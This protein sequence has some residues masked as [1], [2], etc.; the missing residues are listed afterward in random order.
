MPL[1]VRLPRRVRTLTLTLHVLASIGW[2][3]SVAAYLVLA[4]AGRNSADVDVVRAAYLSMG[5]VVTYVIVPLAL[6]ALA[7]GLLQALVSAWGLFRHYWVVAK[8]L[9]ATFGTFLLLMHATQTRSL[10]AAAAAEAL[11]LDGFAGERTKLAILSAGALVMLLVATSLATF[12]P[13]GL[14][15]FG[16][17]GRR[18][19]MMLGRPR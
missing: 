15:P 4:V 12:K 11:S 7:T 6:A 13:A 1:S 17:R 2:F 5:L 18:Q 8:L 14:T 16:R 19:D 3:G 9:L 10:A